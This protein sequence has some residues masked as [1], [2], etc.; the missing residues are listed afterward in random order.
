MAFDGITISN[1]VKELNDTILNGRIAKIAQPEND[2]LL[3]TIK[4]AKGQVR[5]VIS[6]SASLPLIYLSRDNKPSPMTAPNFCMLLRKHIA[7]GRIV[8]ISQPSLERIIRFEIEHL[9]ELG[10]LCRKSLIVEIM[11]KHSNII[12]CNEKGMII[13]SIKHVSAQMSSVR[14]VLPGREYFIPDT[15]K[16][17]NPLDIPEENFTQELL[18]KP[19]PVG[20]AIYNSF[21]GISPVVAEEI[22]H[23]AGIDSSIPA[24][25]M[26][27]DLLSHLYRQFTYFM[28]QVT[29]RKFSPAIYYEGNE[30]KEFSSLPLTHFSNYQVKSFDSI[31]EV[32]RTYYSSRDLIT[33][34]RQKSSDLRRVVQT[35]LERNRKKYDLQLKQLR[36]TENR[37]KYKVYGE[38]IHTYGYNLE[39]GAKELE[40]L[41]Y[42]TNEMIKIPLDPQKTPQENAKKYFDRYNKQKRT[43]EALSELIK[44][45]KDEID[46]L[47]SVSKSLDIARSEDDLIQIK[48]EL[49]ESGFIR[50]KQSS[51][52]VKITSKPFHY[53]SSDGFHMYV[54]KNNLQNEELTFHFANGGDWWFHAKKAPGSHVIVKTNGEEL[55]DRTFEE[56]ARLAAH[57]S[58]N[59]GAEKV[60]V[61]YVEKKQVK[62]PN[63][64]KPGFVVY[65]TNYSMMIDSDIS[66]IQEVL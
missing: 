34:I 55:P 36:D 9:D 42:Y 62:K 54:G 3:L 53:I 10:D 18:S 39:E 33:R 28:E 14:E 46:Y 24:S 11:G 41:N 45:T 40:A 50:R 22:C 31:S 2:E 60:E 25:E 8:G 32:I 17:E 27:A 15:M 6:A 64:S 20:K 16:K 56:A 21:T 48:E 37:D 38:L 63:G 1:I 12:F 7:N 49:I 35:A 5:L 66:G 61:D 44:E 47:E 52:K 59:S 23:L 4:P 57:Y 29:E 65:Y 19:M 26:S 58:K 43:F 51:K 30:P 13:D